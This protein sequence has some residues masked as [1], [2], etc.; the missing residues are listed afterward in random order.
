MYNLVTFSTFIELGNHH[1]NSVL[2]SIPFWFKESKSNSVPH[3][4]TVCYSIF[5][6]GYNEK[7]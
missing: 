7:R 5:N 2:E 6:K 3:D 4:I 1:H